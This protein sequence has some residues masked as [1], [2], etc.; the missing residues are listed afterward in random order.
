MSKGFNYKKATQAINFFV[1]EKE[2]EGEN[3]TKLYA[4]KLVYLADRYHLRK[5]GRSIT[6]DV[7]YA[8]KLGPVAS[9]VKDVIEGSSFLLSK[10]DDNPEEDYFTEYLERGDNHHIFSLAD[11]DIDVFSDT[12]IEALSFAL[13][14]F[15]DVDLVN[16]TH[17]YPE[18]KKFEKRLENEES[19]RFAMNVLDFFENP[20]EGTE[21]KF[22]HDKDILESSKEEFI[23]SNDIEKILSNY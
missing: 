11:V 18:W 20:E 15:K 4:L 1:R 23:E 22:D 8:M 6:N 7:Y 16:E 9:S 14:N 13:E 3:L 5:Y 19:S 17:K 10:E 2:S 12:D 21:D